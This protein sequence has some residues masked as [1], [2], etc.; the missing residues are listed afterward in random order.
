MKAPFSSCRLAGLGLA[1]V[2]L[3]LAVS[4]TFAATDVPSSPF[5]EPIKWKSTGPLVAPVSN[6][7]HSLVSIK[8]PT[9]VQ[10]NGKWHVY[11]TVASTA[12]GWNMVY[13]NFT[14]WSQAGTAP[15]VYLDTANPGLS[16]YHC[17]PQL[18]YFRPQ[19]KWYLIYQSQQPTYSTADDPSK[20]ET[21]SRPQNFFATTPPGAPAN[22]IDY[23][24]ICDDANAYLF[25]SADD[26][27]WY[28]CKTT[29]ANFPNGFSAP[30]IVMQTPSHFDLFEASCVYRLKGT[31]QYLAFIE[32]IGKNGN[33]Y[34]K[35]FLADHLDGAWTPH[36]AT[37]SNPFA[38]LNNVSY[39]I[40]VTPWTRDISHGEL[41]RDGYDETLT[42]DP[43]NLQ[44]LYQG[45]DQATP[46]GVSYSQLPYR[47]ALLRQDITVPVP[48]PV[49]GSNRFLDIS[50]R[51][52]VGQGSSV[53]IA[54]FILTVPSVVLVRAGG[55]ALAA[56]GVPSTLARPLLTIFDSNGKAILSNQGWNK[57]ATYL[58]GTTAD[59]ASGNYRD[60]YGIS[61]V[62][63]AVQAFQF[64]SPDDSAITLQLPAGLYT[65]EVQGADGGTGNALIEVYLYKPAD[66]PAAGN[67]FSAISTRCFVGTGD[68]AA[69]VGLIIED[70]AKILLRAVGPSLTQLG[71]DGVLP[72]PTITLYDVNKQPI[73]ANT[74]WRA[75]PSQAA[76]IQAAAITVNDF[77]L[78][79]DADSALLVNLP[80]GTYTA[81]ITDANGQTGNAT[82]EAYLLPDGN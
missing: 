31:N 53:G 9:I 70:S 18:F 41:I 3:S 26:G 37:E 51:C 23:W 62:T 12:G 40:G 47:L 24:V 19:Q 5:T 28:R 29:L 17:A 50:T 68:S 13:L 44:F 4:A 36:D 74:G 21:W 77:A 63:D 79:T 59:P 78:T 80:A 66:R 34:F 25:F 16:G 75:D 11:A 56:F 22:W 54:G 48:P 58:N 2:L 67:H 20:P 57:G 65:A 52:Y 42:V 35:S 64:S 15:Q 43:G 46:A 7:S 81:T 55:P 6:A 27:C 38:G 71:V 69:I 49:P 14:D 73:Y 10:Y 30:V 45:L 72:H 8:D 82:V 76:L 61:T 60:A 1:W 33:R 32:C 39:N